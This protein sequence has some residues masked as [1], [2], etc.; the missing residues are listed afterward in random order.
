[1]VGDALHALIRG[2]WLAS[3]PPPPSVPREQF[4]PG[5]PA[6]GAEQLRAISPEA[7][8]QGLFN[9]LGYLS[10][11]EREEMA[12]GGPWSPGALG[13]GLVAGLSRMR[14]AVPRIAPETSDV[15]RLFRKG[16]GEGG[17]EWYTGFRPLLER[18][19]PGRE[20]PAAGAIAALSPRRAA[21]AW[22]ATGKY[23]RGSNLEVFHNIW[24]VYEGAGFG[25]K[26][27]QAVEEM[28]GPGKQAVG[29]VGIPLPHKVN[30][31]RALRG[32][33]IGNLDPGE[34][35]KFREFQEAL[36]NNPNAIVLDI[37]MKRIFY[38]RNVGGGSFT[39][40]QYAA[41]AD[42]INNFAAQQGVAPVNVQAALWVAKKIEMEGLRLG[43][44]P[45]VETMREVWA[46]HGKDLS[47]FGDPKVV[48]PTFA[49]AT[50][51]LRGQ[52]PRTAGAAEESSG[53]RAD[54]WR[55]IQR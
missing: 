5:S 48:L 49:I 16:M 52:D 41:T 32:E 46:H 2:G 14:Q 29:G 51:L 39:P 18:L 4:T 10:P 44:K 15:E 30:V 21:G 19:M 13:G 43:T 9:M 36:L 3:T 11:E 23:N 17:G 28:V 7:E 53:P 6:Q 22:T 54:L 1:M 26:G 47:A 38:P 50:M 45:F 40:A 33:T 24:D 55:A 8:R 20:R 25:Q 31:Q 34:M 12:G 37:W 27:L 35:M 42:F